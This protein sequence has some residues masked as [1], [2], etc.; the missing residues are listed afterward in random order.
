MIR[1]LAPFIRAETPNI[2]R[3]DAQK[4]LTRLYETDDAMI[5]ADI[6]DEESP[7]AE[8]IAH[9]E[10]VLD[11]PPRQRTLPKKELKRAV[12]PELKKKEK[13][14]A[15]DP[16]STKFSSLLSKFQGM[17]SLEP[18]PSIILRSTQTPKKALS[19]EE[20]Q[21]QFIERLQGKLARLDK[22]EPSEVFE[23]MTTLERNKELFS[24]A[25]QS[26][27]DALISALKTLREPTAFKP[28]PTETALIAR[29]GG[30]LTPYGITSKSY[31]R[32]VNPV[33]RETKAELIGIIKANGDS[34]T[35]LN[36]A[37]TEA[38]PR[39]ETQA[40]SQRFIGAEILEKQTKKFTPE[41]ALNLA[42]SVRHLQGFRKEAEEYFHTKWSEV[43]KKFDTETGGKFSGVIKH[44]GYCNLEKH[45]DAISLFVVDKHLST[46]MNPVLLQK[47]AAL[48]P[49][50]FGGTLAGLREQEV[51]LYQAETKRKYVSV[52]SD[53]IW[54]RDHIDFIKKVYD[55]GS[56]LNRNMGGGTCERNSEDRVKLLLKTP[57]I[58]SDRIDMGSTSV[59]R[60]NQVARNIMFNLKDTNPK[61]AV[62]ILKE[63]YSRVGLSIDRYNKVAAKS[64][65]DP[66]EVLY[67]ELGR[68]VTEENESIFILGM[69]GE[70]REGHAINI[71]VDLSKPIFR[72][73][74]DNIGVVECP[75]GKT[76]KETLTTWLK[77][78]Y[79]DLPNYTL[80]TLS[81]I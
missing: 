48:S 77:T 61:E 33:Q 19:V 15:P 21:H 18:S 58:T 72:F 11:T 79:P 62:R 26:G 67:S 5:Q 59:G 43:I 70:D 80:M 41:M 29:W 7:I 12:A 81:T 52:R 64:D 44:L 36:K 76:F 49:E 78:A 24:K 46:F 40:I 2:S 65:E 4:L 50:E 68:L 25:D 55:Q 16:R 1:N 71:Q 14:E 17:E 10:K 57:H 60:F 53:L 30:L 6:L 69:T 42:N 34:F 35:S 45:A 38:M 56:D 9:L 39:L 27:I 28:S 66:Q 73:I 75:D 32:T 54:I 74:D 37:L 63:S 23:L 47:A 31:E 8:G 3:T 51:S 13:V 20:K 22:M